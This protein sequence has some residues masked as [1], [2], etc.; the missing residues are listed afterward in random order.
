MSMLGIWIGLRSSTMKGDP[1]CPSSK[2]YCMV[3]IDQMPPTSSFSY[4]LTE[5]VADLDPVHAQVDKQGLVN[6]PLFVELDRHLVDDLELPRS[7]TDRLD[8]L[9]LVGTDVVLGQDAS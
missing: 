5:L 2:K 1:F 6:V 7:R 4:F 3:M 9:G 8:L